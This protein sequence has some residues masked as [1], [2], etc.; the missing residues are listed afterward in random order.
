MLVG[1]VEK[2]YFFVESLAEVHAVEQ[3]SNQWDSKSWILI[4]TTLLWIIK[5]S[6]KYEKLFWS[7]LN[8]KTHNTIWV[9]FAK[10]FQKLLLWETRGVIFLVLEILLSKR[11]YDRLLLKITVIRTRMCGEVI[12]SNIFLNVP[13]SASFL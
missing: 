11:H 7:D 3:S 13:F 5:Y 12:A 6:Q 2:L 10:Y 8:C 4:Y 9:F 1:K